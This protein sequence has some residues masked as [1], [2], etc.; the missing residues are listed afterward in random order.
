[1]KPTI[2]TSIDAIRQAVAAARARGLTVGL[3]PTMGALHAG[4]ASLIQAARADTGFVVVS[5]FVNPL[6]FGPAEDFTRYPRPLEDDLQ[7]CQRESVDAVFVPETAEMY[8]N[9]FRT[10]VEVRELQNVLCG[11]SRPGHFRGVATV[12]LKLLNIVQPDIAYFGQKDAQ[13]ARII[14]QMVRDLAVPVRLRICPII[15]AAAGLALSS[16]NQYLDP[17][18]R[19]QAVVLHQALEEARSLVMKGERDAAVVQQAITA[20]IATAP[21]AVLDYAAIVDADTLQ[22]VTH[23]QGSVLIALAVKFGTTRLIDNM[24]VS[25]V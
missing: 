21:G 13:Q 17:G 5:V 9:G 22:P 15:R 10:L 6:Q 16:R 7:L 11:A 8:P 1:M 20:R 23:L 18:Q 25:S 2:H 3:V 4:H 24:I 12:V 14:Q 19:L